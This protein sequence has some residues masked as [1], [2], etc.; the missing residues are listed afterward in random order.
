MASEFLTNFYEKHF[1]NETLV[2]LYSK[3]VFYK[4]LE[5]MNNKGEIKE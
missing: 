1:G 2:P 5:E 4:L 3:K